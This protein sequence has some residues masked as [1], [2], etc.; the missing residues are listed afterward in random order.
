MVTRIADLDI[1]LKR[2][3]SRIEYLESE[4]NSQSFKRVW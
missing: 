3:I 2:K 4:T 1:V